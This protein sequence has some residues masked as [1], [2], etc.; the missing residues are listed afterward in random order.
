MA[1]CARHRSEN[2]ASL[3]ACM[4]QEHRKEAA[5]GDSCG[6]E[7]L[8]VVARSPLHL[9]TRPALRGWSINILLPTMMELF[10]Y[11]IQYYRGGHAPR[12]KV[13]AYGGTG[14]R[15]RSRCKGVFG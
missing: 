11:G 9:P 12:P 4:Q 3:H 13:R 15:L 6:S 1:T 10:V 2:R 14:E 8:L 7:A 5:D